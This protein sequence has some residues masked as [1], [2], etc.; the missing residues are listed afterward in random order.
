[1]VTLVLF[2]I[3][4]TRLR[5]RVERICRDAGMDRRQF[6][7]FAGFLAEDRRERLC[8]RL[9]EIVAAHAETE[10]AEKRKQALVVDV[11]VLCAADAAKAIRINREGLRVPELPSPRGVVIV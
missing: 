3:G 7:A 5:T 9:N 1:M 4:D 6:S 2:D 8:E 10:D 11:F